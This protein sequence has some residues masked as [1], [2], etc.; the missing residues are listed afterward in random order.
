MKFSIITVSH[1]SEKTI[2]DT[3]VSVKEQSYK[4]FE[5][6]FIDGGS[7]DKTL[8]LINC[9]KNENSIVLSENDDGIYDAFN[10]GI[11]LASGDL[12]SILNSD[13][14]FYDANV[15]RDVSDDFLKNKCDIVY[16]DLVCVAQKDLK[17]IKRYWKSSRYIP[18][19]FKKGW[20]PPHPTFFVK[21]SVYDEYGNFDTSFEVSAD[22]ELMLRFIEIKKSSVSYLPKTLVKMR[23]GGNSQ[24]IA[25]IFIGGKNILNAFKIN[26]IYV[27]PFMYFFKRYLKKIF[28]FV[29]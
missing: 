1:N 2:K 3:I 19:S 16:G 24:N 21:K 18:N 5:H 27:N 12:I 20:H 6:I 4:N 17:K 28:Q 10:K 9:Y 13:D 29:F 22:F 7:T 26:G 15:L 8:E 11:S 14:V 23:V 25:N